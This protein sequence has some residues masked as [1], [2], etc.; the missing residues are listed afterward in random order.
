LKSYEGEESV[1]HFE[2][3]FDIIAPVHA[4]L[5]FTNYFQIEKQ[6]PEKIKIKY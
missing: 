4:S 2:A 1:V 5:V 3:T 6:K